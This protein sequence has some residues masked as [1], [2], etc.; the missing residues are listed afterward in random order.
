MRVIST[1]FTSA[2]I[3]LLGLATLTHSAPI[4]DPVK[5]YVTVLNPKNWDMQVAKNRAKGITIVHF[6]QDTGKHSFFHLLS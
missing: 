6:Y 4:Y 3:A 2:I 1:I 5:S